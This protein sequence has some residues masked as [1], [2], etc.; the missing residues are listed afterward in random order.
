MRS[1]QILEENEIR[2]LR[3]LSDKLF[4]KCGSEKYYF[5]NGVP[6]GMATSPACYD[7]YMEDFL[8]QVRLRL[9]NEGI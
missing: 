3:L 7:I 8:E 1:E 9:I 4:F 5:A 6:Q 2:F